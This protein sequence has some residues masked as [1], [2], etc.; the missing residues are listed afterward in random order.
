MS[1][2]ITWNDSIYGRLKQHNDRALL[3]LVRRYNLIKRVCQQVKDLV[4]IYFSLIVY[5]IMSEKKREAKM[6]KKKINYANRPNDN[7]KIAKQHYRSLFINNFF[8]DK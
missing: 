6:K 7:N 2:F 1:K 5:T 3:L 8:L 4:S